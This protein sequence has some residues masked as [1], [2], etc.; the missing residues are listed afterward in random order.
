MKNQAMITS[1]SVI[2]HQE[3]A[4]FPW[5]TQKYKLSPREVDVVNLLVLGK[6]D[7][8]IHRNIGISIHTVREHLRHIRKKMGV[9]SRLEIV[10]ILLCR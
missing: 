9:C 1:T 2:P 6:S 8:I 10:S 7:K 4:H 5:A 3:P